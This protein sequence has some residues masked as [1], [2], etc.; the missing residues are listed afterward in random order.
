MKPKLNWAEQA[1][2]MS[3]R[4]LAI[5]DADACISFL[6]TH[7]YYRFSGYA[8]YFQQ[9]PQNG[10]DR[11]CEGISF[12]AIRNIYEA[13][14]TI[15]EILACQLARAEILLRTHVAYV[16]AQEYGPYGKYLE[17]S[18]YADVGS[19][20]STAEFCLHDIRRSKERHILHYQGEDSSFSKLPIWSAVEALSFGTLS[21]CIERGALGELHPKIA[22]SLGVAKAGFAY[23]VRSLVY[24]RNRCAHHSR[25]WNHSVLDAGPTPNN[26][27]VKAKKKAG[28]FQPRSV[29][30]VVASLDD[31]VVKGKAGEAVLPRLVECYRGDKT[32]WDGLADPKATTDH[33]P[34]G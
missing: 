30:D 24:L 19:A 7:N 16:I 33:F 8:R 22:T 11:F 20:E 15:R 17:P 10:D 27:R 13:D 32:I 31:M 9:S 25:L 34:K 28:Q 14:V 26:V 3:S 4:G 21:K 1:S 6:T 2:L 23:R 5:E 18:F 29:M 12:D